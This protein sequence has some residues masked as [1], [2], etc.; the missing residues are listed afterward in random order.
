MGYLFSSWEHTSTAFGEGKGCNFKVRVGAADI[1]GQKLQLE[2]HRL[3]RLIDHVHLESHIPYFQTHAPTLENIARF[4][5]ENTQFENLV[6][7]VDGNEN[8]RAR[9]DGKQ[10]EL[11]FNFS[12]RNAR[13]V[14][15]V[16]VT[17]AGFISPV[18]GMILDRDVLKEVLSQHFVVPEVVSSPFIDSGFDQTFN[19]IKMALLPRKLVSIVLSDAVTGKVLIV[20]DAKAQA[21]LVKPD[22][23]L[24]SDKSE[25]LIP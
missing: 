25:H 19:A 20:K 1:G 13:R 18:H 9:C 15:N 12:A 14:F 11:I 5:R 16:E 17:V 3:S 6:V 7:E 23:G 8:F 2:A 24:T 22:A 21:P 10:N 4:L